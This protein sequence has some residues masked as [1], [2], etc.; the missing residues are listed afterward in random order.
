MEIRSIEY[1]DREGLQRAQARR[2][3]GGSHLPEPAASA[4]SIKADVSRLADEFF[5]GLDTPKEDIPT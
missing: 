2:A 3:N 1:Y 4:P 5:N